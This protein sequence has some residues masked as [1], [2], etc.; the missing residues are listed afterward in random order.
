MLA[1]CSGTGE[2][3]SKP[4]L[5]VCPWAQNGGTDR[6]ARRMAALLEEDLG[7][8]VNVLNATGGEGVS[9][10]SQGANAKPDGYTLTLMTVEIN[11]LRWRGR[12]KLSHR[13][14]TP[15]LL[16]NRDPAA[17]FVRED[18]PWMTLKELEDAVRRAP[19]TL[20]A[21]G[22]AMG[23]IWHLALAGWLVSAGLK[24]SD[25]TW[26]ASQGSTPALRDLLAKGSDLVSCSL[27]EAKTLMLAKEIR[28]LGVMAPERQ[29]L[30]PD[31]PTFA[32]QGSSWTMGAWRGV[33]LPRGVP[34]RVLDVLVP[35]L[36]RAARSEPF[37]EYMKTEG[38]G[39]ACELPADFERS[40]EAT[41]DR[42]RGLLT[43]DAFASLS[44]NRFS[45]M[46]FPS[47]LGGL[48]AAVVGALLATRGL[49]LEPGGGTATPL[50]WVRFGEG[51]LFIAA[52]ALF[53][54]VAGFILTAGPLLFLAL[55]RLGTRP[56]FAAP[57]AAGAA[58]LAYV[59]FGR[60]LRVPLPRGW[61]EW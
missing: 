39:P 51:L 37:L 46:L 24:P 21:S 16:V 26:V 6:V 36:A 5:I 40:L 22:T 7:V 17:I 11:M 53:S 13:D 10:H 31:V 56:R 54:G 19:E 43:S 52:Y 23:G 38:F 50:G 49:R 8:N 29:A 60:L 27:P 2:Y 1:G 25:I 48:L 30:F 15:A 12:T 47:I 58:L 61:I 34:Q 45:P 59:V 28:C 35:A 42:M 44:K 18:A 3:P 33:G 9:G 57:I 55:W 41:D 4:I 32:E 20:R 14:F